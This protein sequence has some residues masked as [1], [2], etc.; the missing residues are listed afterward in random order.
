MPAWP[1][2]V[3]HAVGT[4]LYTVALYIGPRHLRRAAVLQLA[5]LGSSIQFSS[6]QCVGEPGGALVMTGNSA[7]ITRNYQGR[8]YLTGE[9]R[10][11]LHT[12]LS[13]ASSSVAPTR[14]PSTVDSSSAGNRLTSCAAVVRLYL[15]GE[16]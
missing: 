6:F 4:T 12:L 2:T 1:Y 13:S 8:N 3:E 15:L 7:V 14:L 16:I 10:A 5:R 9:G 11:L